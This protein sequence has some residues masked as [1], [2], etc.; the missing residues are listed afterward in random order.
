MARWAPETSVA[1]KDKRCPDEAKG[2]EK[3]PG[4][5]FGGETTW[6]CSVCIHIYCI[7][8]LYVYNIIYI[9]IYLSDIKYN[10]DVPFEVG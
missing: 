4:G 6:T 5:L 3:N 1:R 10:I 8:V 9:Y 7:Y 2:G